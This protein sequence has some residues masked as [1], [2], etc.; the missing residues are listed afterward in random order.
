MDGDAGVMSLVHTEVFITIDNTINQCL[1]TFFF[2]RGTPKIIFIS[3]GAPT[4]E[5]VY[6]PEN[7]DSEE[8][9]SVTAKLLSINLFVKRYYV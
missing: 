2:Y 5:N 4:Y 3:R 9:C 8:R 6:R 1:P 7:F